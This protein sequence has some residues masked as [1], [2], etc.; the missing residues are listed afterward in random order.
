MGIC[1]GRAQMRNI[2]YEE[3]KA[4]ERGK[5]RDRE[6]NAFLYGLLRSVGGENIVVRA[7]S[8]AQWPWDESEGQ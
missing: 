6:G 2:K 5:E 4:R 8:C 3:E 1:F 7:G